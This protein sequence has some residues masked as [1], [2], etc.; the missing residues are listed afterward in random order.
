[1]LCRYDKAANK[2]E[3]L[4]KDSVDFKISDGHIILNYVLY[5]NVSTVLL[6]CAPNSK[7]EDFVELPAAGSQNVS[8]CDKLLKNLL[9]N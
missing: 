9:I 4:G 5:N 2:T 6:E 1:M 3:V 7:R 8:H